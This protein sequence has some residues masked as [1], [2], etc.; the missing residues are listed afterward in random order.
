MHVGE[1]AIFLMVLKMYYSKYCHM[2]LK[3]IAYPYCPCHTKWPFLTNSMRDAIPLYFILVQKDIRCSTDLM[4]VFFINHQLW[5][6]IRTN[7]DDLHKSPWRRSISRTCEP[8][9]I[10][11]TPGYSTFLPVYIDV[12]GGKALHC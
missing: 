2:D 4:V 5:S 8:Q 7:R 6:L 10:M 1:K 12:A 9:G 11:Y 3:N